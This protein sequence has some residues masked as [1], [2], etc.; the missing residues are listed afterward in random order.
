MPAARAP[1]ARPQ[2]P[3]EAFIQSDGYKAI[4]DAGSR[5]TTWTSG[6]VDCGPLPMLTKG[7]LL[8]G[9]GAP[10]SGTG[11]GWIP[12]PQV[13][14]GVV[15]KLFQPLTFENLLLGG[16]AT[17]P[18]VRY[19]TEGTATSAAAGVAEGGLKPES[20]ARVQHPGRADQEDR[21]DRSRSATS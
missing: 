11:G 5:S 8:E 16:L 7:T 10:G 3:G 20:H 9:A 17:G 19:A 6:A 15:D 4:S 13:V 2:R 1:S 14:P 18:V 12:V 21:H